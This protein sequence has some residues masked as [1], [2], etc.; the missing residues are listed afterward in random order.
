MD[1]MYS[2]A[3][4]APLGSTIMPA[5]NIGETARAFDSLSEPAGEIGSNGIPMVRRSE[6]MAVP[7]LE[8]SIRMAVGLQRLLRSLVFCRPS[9]YSIR[10]LK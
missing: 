6:M 2:S 3:Q 9:T 4:D 7:L 5:S 8:S 1:S 10:A